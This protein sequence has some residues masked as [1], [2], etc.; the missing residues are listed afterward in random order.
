MFEYKTLN[1]MLRRADD[2]FS[3]T[4]VC[5]FDTHKNEH[6]TTYS[7]LYKTAVKVAKGLVTAGIKKNDKILMQFADPHKYAY[8]FWGTLF[9][10]AVPMALPFAFA[11]NAGAEVMEKQLNIC[12]KMEK[13]YI[14][15][16]E[17]A[18]QKYV[19][20]MKEWKQVM[21]LSIDKI[22]A[23]ADVRVEIPKVEE[24]D[25]A[26]VLF[27]SGSTSDPK[28]V[29][30]SHKT[31]VASINGARELIQYRSDDRILSFLPMTHAFGF[32]GFHLVPIACGVFQC[33]MPTV[34]FVQQP[35]D[36]MKRLEEWNITMFGAMNF[37]LKLLMNQLSYDQIRSLNLKNIKHMFMGGEPVN[38]DLIESFL[39]K[40]MPAGISEMAPRPI[41]GLSESAFA[42]SCSDI[43]KKFRA[44][45]L[46]FEKISKENKVEFAE[47]EDSVKFV[48]VGYPIPG[49][50][51]LVLDDNGNPLS[52]N[53]VGEFYYKGDCISEGYLLAE[54]DR[55]KKMKNGYLASGDMGYL[56]GGEIIITGRK[57]DI[58]FI[59]GQNYY[60]IDI[61]NMIARLMPQWRERALICQVY[62]SRSETEILLFVV[63]EE[64]SES[65]AK[66]AR[67]LD[68]KIK[69]NM[70]LN[71]RHYIPIHEIPKTAS[72]KIKRRELV[73]RY[74]GGQ[75]HEKIEELNKWMKTE[76]TVDDKDP[77]SQELQQIW[78]HVLGLNE[79][80][81]VSNFFEGGGDSIKLIRMAE[82]LQLR[83]GISV[84]LKELIHT[85]DIGSFIELVRRKYE[86]KE[87]NEILT[88]SA[89]PDKKYEPFDLTDIQLAY[90][91]GRDAA[92]DMGG[93]ATHGY[94]EYK[95]ALNLERFEKALNKVIHYQDNLRM[96]MT[97]DGKQKILKQVPTYKIKTIDCTENS[98]EETKQILAKERERMSHAVF[99]PYYWPLFEFE[100]IKIK[101]SEYVLLFGIDLLI[102][103]ASSLQ[104]FK[105]LIMQSYENPTLMWEPLEFS[106]RDFMDGIRLIHGSKKYQEDRKYWRNKVEDFPLSPK[107]PSIKETENLEKTVF[108][109]IQLS[110]EP[111]RMQALKDYAKKQNIS[112]SALI[113]TVYAHVLSYW[114]NQS[115]CA[116]NVTIFNKYNFHK[117]VK[118]ILGDF[119]SNMFLAFRFEESS[120]LYEV[121]AKVQNE[122][123]EGLEHRYYSGVEFGRDLKFHRALQNKAV[124]PIVFTSVLNDM[125]DQYLEFGELLYGIS[126]TSQVYL[127]CQVYEIKKNLVVSWDYIEELFDEEVMHEMFEQFKKELCILADA[128]RELELQEL[129][130]KNEKRDEF[131]VEY[132][133]TE[134][135]IPVT[136]LHGLF[137]QS[138]EKYPKRIAVVDYERAITYKELKEASDAMAYSLIKYGVQKGEHVAVLSERKIST[139][140]SIL[141][142][143]KAGGVYVPIDC[144]NPKARQE[145]ILKESECRILLGR[146]NLE[147]GM[148]CSCPEVQCSD[149]AYIIYTSGSTG[150]A[151]G[152]V[153]THEGAANTILDINQQ[154]GVNPEDKIIGLSSICFDLSVYDIFGAFAA[155]AS[156]YMVRDVHSH[157]EIRHL[158]Q[159]EGITIWNSVPALMQ[160]YLDELE[161]GMNYDYWNYSEN[162]KIEISEDMLRLVLLSGDWIPVTLPARIK[163]CF[164]DITVVSLGGATDASIWS[165]SYP[166][167]HVAPEW[168]SIPYGMPLKNQKIF[169][170]NYDGSDS[171]IGTAGEI[172]IGGIGVAQEYYNDFEKTEA[173]F[174]EHVRYGRLYRT[175]DYGKYCK[176]G[177]VEFL[178]RRDNQIKVHGHRIELGEI[179]H[180]LQ[181]CQ[182]VKQAVALCR[183]DGG[184][185]IICGY[186]VP[187]GKFHQAEIKSEL[188]ELV[189]A[190]MIPSV[191]VS[192]QE[193]P[194]TSNQ[195]VDRKALMKLEIKEEKK[196]YTPPQ[197][198]MQSKLCEIWEEILETSP[199]GIHQNFYDLGGDSLRLLKLLARIESSIHVKVS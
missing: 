183:K 112:I 50:E 36:F 119:T 23:E 121:V 57:K 108:R 53:M 158:V 129:L 27:S 85:L 52:E 51:V 61:E 5:F 168:K 29:V 133:C 102:M 184:T 100:A 118:H 88:V 189:P 125:N 174:F 164:E 80:Q 199:I 178:G 43:H 54:D 49:L 101:E 73:E 191:L 140:V 82:E 187:E 185:P 196:E 7:G 127:D 148:I 77:F 155:G 78:N 66:Q 79:T 58:I 180:A 16:T 105:T 197:T 107:L 167:E 181:K 63:D 3:D 9:S 111:E 190:Y 150:K 25:T 144:E 81:K 15:T 95:F 116:I 198:Q 156:L 14:L 172:C 44:D 141:G 163:D 103:D 64:P 124:M 70:F 13:I 67:E 161:Q 115:T 18:Y 37:V 142:I 75:Y 8:G 192:I 32:I 87:E 93:I 94:Y 122:L 45:S 19:S 170:L 177:Y 46:S 39:E 17:D 106:F 83:L 91:M 41:Y 145:L 30:L 165:I 153:I 157:E 159:E 109:R 28:G 104:M 71:I 171:P 128:D 186:V 24:T 160:I 4:E 143:L 176:D 89:E 169:V 31:V 130:P 114:S 38:A 48:S 98:E 149:V 86:E 68:K 135:C 110:L 34:M 131:V 65:F 84:S 1:E 117:D 194:Y 76:T 42:I 35:F 20:L 6:R 72:G 113:C 59:N 173:S 182:G 69:E 10:G 55:N 188:A 175:G 120:Y 62:T 134:A 90:L 162:Q 126:Q 146:D 138:A 26:C 12:K 136:T 179:E 97:R 193:M 60:P 56:S 154:Y 137:A 2:K 92:Y 123:L 166:I 22:M 96:V 139:I 147:K 11:D 152:V 21:V 132:N 47:G 195:K 99:N 40:F 33:I 151:K 74:L